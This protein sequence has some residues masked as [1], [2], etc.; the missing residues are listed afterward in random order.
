IKKTYERAVAMSKI[1]NNLIV[2]IYAYNGEGLEEPGGEP[3]KQVTF[4]K[5]SSPAEA[6]AKAKDKI[7]NILAAIR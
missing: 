4:D 3:V 1:I 6:F 2:N 7:I 5:A